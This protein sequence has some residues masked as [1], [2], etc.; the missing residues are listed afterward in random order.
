MFILA[1]RIAVRMRPRANPSAYD[2]FCLP[3]RR[4]ILDHRD[5]RLGLKSSRRLRHSRPQSGAPP[6]PGHLGLGFAWPPA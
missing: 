3:R 5:Q 6:R 2:S 4:S 1:L